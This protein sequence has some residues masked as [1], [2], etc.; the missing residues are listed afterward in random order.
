MIT[1]DSTINPENSE[2]EIEDQSGGKEVE[3]DNPL[4]KALE[5]ERQNARKAAREVS[6]LKK[7][8]EALGSIDPEEYKTL[9][10]QREEEQRKKQ[11][12]KGQYQ[13]IIA[14]KDKLIEAERQKTAEA[15]AKASKALSR[16]LLTQSFTKAEG[17]GDLLSH[18]L[19]VVGDLE[20]DEDGNPIIPVVVKKD[21]SEVETL[22]EYV[23]HIRDNEPGFGVY[24]KPLNKAAGSGDLGGKAPKVGNPAFVSAAEAYKYLDEIAAGTVQV[25]Y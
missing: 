20:I 12:E 9:K 5:A 1:E 11:E 18:F 4:K 24:F 13:S 14:D 16:V 25:K 15:T 23:A 17:Y 10:Q 21:G 6:A 2:E 7:Q 3:V 19:K 22:D 8:L